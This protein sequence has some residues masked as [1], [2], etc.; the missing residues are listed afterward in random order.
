[1]KENANKISTEN[2]YI[3]CKMKEKEE[4]NA[5]NS[6]LAKTKINIHT[7]IC[8]S[9]VM[10]REQRFYKCIIQKNERNKKVQM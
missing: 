9:K 3:V 7:L 1:M 6:A 8:Y 5:K 4:K 2:V 10:K